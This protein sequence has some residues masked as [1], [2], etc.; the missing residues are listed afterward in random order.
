MINKNKHISHDLL[1]SYLLGEAN[2]TQLAEVEDWLQLSDENRK[3]LDKL[4][5]L[6]IETGKISP[7]P[8]AVDIDEAWTKMDNRIEES[9]KTIKLPE[10]KHIVLKTVYRIAAIFILAIGVYAILKITTREPNQI[11]LASTTETLRDSLPDGSQ[12]ALNINSKITYPE[13]FEENTREVN[14]EGEAFFDVEHDPQK[15]FI[16]HTSIGDV[17]VLGTSFNVKAY[18]LSGKLEVIVISGK[19]Q[20]IKKDESKIDATSV[21]LEPGTKGII[22]Q[23]SLKIKK[24]EEV[25]P[26]TL[27]WNSKMLIFE[28]AKLSFVFDLLERHYDI[29][30]QVTND[31]IENCLLSATFDDEEIGLILQIISESFNLN[32]K[33]ENNI[34][35]LEG[36]GC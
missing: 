6:W 22:E 3:S 14:L 8:V 33:Q 16:V 19:V 4:D 23:K 24:V 29:S 25:D 5:K 1:M 10:R 26:N 20:L 12:I 9:V 36:N 28:E 35:I 27:F 31:S 11:I 15:P 21:I 18:T 32:I 30:I 34:F 2:S 7:P 13:T 17:K